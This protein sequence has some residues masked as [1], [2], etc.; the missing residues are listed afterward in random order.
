MKACSVGIVVD[1]NG[2]MIS[3]VS[4]EVDVQLSRAHFHLKAQLYSEASAIAIVGPSGSGKSTFL[5]VLAGLEKKAVGRVRI[6]E[7]FWQDSSQ[8]LFVPPWQ[9]QLG[10]VPQES[11][12]IPTL[13]VF[14][15]L[16]FSGASSDEVKRVA[17]QL[18]IASL[19]YRRPRMLSGGEKQRVALGRALLA[20][21][22][23]LL[24]DEPFSA[25]DRGLRK[26]ISDILMTFCRERGLP[27]FLVSHDDSD[28]LALAQETWSFLD[29]AL[30]PPI[31]HRVI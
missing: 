15:N 30:V 5:R 6:K 24:L 10:Y 1:W 27:L 4:F 31:T 19:L 11:L 13:N 28:V 20:N 12:L 18:E 7:S 9:R 21:P 16:S 3:K 17:E 14:E 26:R 23:L 25:L 2:A 29:G 8:G 22:Q